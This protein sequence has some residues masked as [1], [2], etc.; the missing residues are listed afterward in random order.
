M[1]DCRNVEEGRPY[2]FV[3]TLC[4]QVVNFVV[5]DLLNYTE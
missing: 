5:R 2:I 3:Y 1:V 4:V